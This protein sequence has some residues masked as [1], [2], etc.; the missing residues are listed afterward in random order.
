MT[1]VFI[2]CAALGSAILIIQLIMLLMGFGFDHDV[3]DGHAFEFGGH[4]GSVGDHSFE[5]GGDHDV[6][7]EG[8]F[9]AAHDH[10]VHDH[11]SSWFFSVLS[12]RSVV[13]ALAFF[14]LAGLAMD[15]GGAPIYITVVIACGAGAVAMIIVAWL[16]RLL[17]SL[18]AEGNVRI[19]MAVGMPASVYLRVPGKRSGS[20]KVTVKVQ[21]RT[22]EY[23]AMTDG[24][25]LPTGAPVMVVG[26]I[27]PDTLEVAPIEEGKE[28]I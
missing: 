9:D 11:G 3:G 7:G 16:M 17:Y 27:G 26:V 5:V 13:A 8:H 18:N 14:G 23:L 15:A 19:E 25:A 4:D 1:T 12:V 6:G 2:V 21:E 22:M 28:K 24:G 20:G 10:D